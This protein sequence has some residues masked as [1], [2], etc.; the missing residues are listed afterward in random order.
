MSWLIAVIGSPDR[1]KRKDSYYHEIPQYT[2]SMAGFYLAVGGNPDACFFNH[3]KRTRSGWAVVGSGIRLAEGMASILTWQDWANLL[4]GKI[5]KVTE[6]DGHFAVLR[7]NGDEVEC[8]T[9]Q[10]GLRSIYYCKFDQGICISTRLDWVTCNTGKTTIDFN[11]L[12]SRWL[13]LN[14]VSYDSCVT[15]IKRL[16]PG[17]QAVFKSGSVIQSTFTPWLPSFEPNNPTTAL[18]ILKA[19]VKCALDHKYTPSLGLSGGLDSRLVLAL[20]TGFPQHNFVTHV[21]GDPRDPDVCI[22]NQIA[23]RLDLMHINFHDPLPDVPT[24]ISTFRS[25]IAQTF[26]CESGTSFIN[27]RYYHQLSA[28]KRIV[29]DGGCGEIA[30]RKY[31]NRVAHLGKAVVESPDLTGLLRLLHYRRADIFSPELTQLLSAGACESLRKMIAE[32]PPVR[33]IGIEN[34]VDLVV[35]RTRVPNIV[36]FEQARVDNEVLNFMP[37][38]QPSFLKVIFGVPTRFR[39]NARFH[40]AIIRE[41]NPA[42]TRFALVRSGHTYP[43]GFSNSAAWLLTS[44]KSKLTGNFTDPGP[45]RLLLHIKDYVLDIVHSASVKDE[46]IYDYRKIVDAVTK[47]Y[48]GISSLRSTVDWW[49]TF[50]LWRRSLSPY[51]N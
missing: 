8:F 38:V 35:M 13:L 45:D 27:L 5:F 9:D 39:S 36:G 18:D 40:N 7:W 28:A 33:K 3:D 34:F 37:L 6:L 4:T 50:E 49:L 47:Y 16:G 29:I 22:A 48:Q 32:M 42:L 25:F 10:L 41:S 26:L 24:T 31:L 12:G 30:R 17:G 21:F 44:L 43:F 11:A 20:L 14:Q 46:S 51:K 19:F 15:A 2:V 23:G 1:Q